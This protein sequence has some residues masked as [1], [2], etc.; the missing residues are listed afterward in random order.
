MLNGETFRKLANN[1]SLLTSITIILILSVINFRAL[2]IVHP[3]NRM[4]RKGEKKMA[5][6]SIV[7]AVFVI[8]VSGKVIKCYSN[9]RNYNFIF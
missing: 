9:R 4:N 8:F 5:V 2:I 1:D 6:E 7:I 3:L